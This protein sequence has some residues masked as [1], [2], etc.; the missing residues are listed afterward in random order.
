VGVLSYLFTDVNSNSGFYNRFLPFVILLSFIYG[1]IVTISLFCRSRVKSNN[2]DN[3][4][5]LLITS[6]KDQGLLDKGITA[7]AVYQANVSQAA[8]NLKKQEP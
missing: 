8:P 4:T 5:G 7:T 6:L 2:K 1:V 3:S